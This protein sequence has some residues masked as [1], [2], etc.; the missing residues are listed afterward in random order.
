MRSSLALFLIGTF[1]T[2]SAFAATNIAP[3]G[4]TAA[5][6]AAAAAK[7]APSPARATITS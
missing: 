1:L 2:G 6:P 3:A 7:P 4:N 5:T